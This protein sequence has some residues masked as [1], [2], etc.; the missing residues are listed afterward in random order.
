MKVRC[1]VLCIYVH[2]N[3]CCLMCIVQ[4][5]VLRANQ[6]ICALSLCFVAI[7]TDNGIVL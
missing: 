4:C 5:D 1:K 6:G 7:V 3:E 2:V